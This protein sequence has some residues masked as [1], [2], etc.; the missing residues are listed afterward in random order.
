MSW[1]LI[2]AVVWV[3]LAAPLALL[4]GRA[5]RHADEA[6]SALSFPAVP[7]FL[8]SEWAEPAAEPR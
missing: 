8:P 3:A 6:E 2:A 5:L 4:I 1:V 7:D